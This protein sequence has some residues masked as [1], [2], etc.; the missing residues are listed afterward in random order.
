MPVV[1]SEFKVGMLDAVDQ[2]DNAGSRAGL[3]SER[4]EGNAG[5]HGLVDAGEI[6]GSV[7]NDGAPDWVDAVIGLAF[8]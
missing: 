8:S 7:R 3:K 5:S 1:G 4:K 2:V 6:V